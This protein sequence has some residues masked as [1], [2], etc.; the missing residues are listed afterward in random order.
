MTRISMK[1]A[2]GA[3][4]IAGALILAPGTTTG[5]GSASAATFGPQPGVSA[6]T[7]AVTQVKK[8]GVH[9]H[10]HHRWLYYGL[11]TALVLGAAG[12]G[13][14]SNQADRCADYYGPYTYR[15]RRCMRNAG[16]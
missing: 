2:V 7:S 6:D 5:F 16:C 10:H 8:G 9:H 15:Y 12:A 3:A 13:Y 14:C 11:G 4:A 1:L